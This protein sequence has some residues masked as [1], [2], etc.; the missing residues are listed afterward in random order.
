MFAMLTRGSHLIPLEVN[1]RLE[2]GFRY[3]DVHWLNSISDFK[4]NWGRL[5]SILLILLQSEKS[6][7]PRS[8]VLVEVLKRSLFR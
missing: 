7:G 5:D 8:E 4:L 2:S 3:Q 6:N 1:A